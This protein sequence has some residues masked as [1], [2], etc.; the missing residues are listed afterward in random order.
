MVSPFRRRSVLS[1]RAHHHLRR[2]NPGDGDPQGRAPGPGAPGEAQGGRARRHRPPAHDTPPGRGRAALTSA[3]VL[4]GC[5][6]TVAVDP[7]PD[8][9]NPDCAPVM[10]AMPDEVS[11]MSSGRRPGRHH[12]LRDPSHHDRALRRRDWGPPPEPCTD[13]S[14]V[15]W[16]ISQVPR[17]GEPV[18]GSDL[19]PFTSGRGAL[20]RAARA[21]LDRSGGHRLRQCRASPGA[22]CESVADEEGA[23]SP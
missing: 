8:A 3:V 13:V 7:L 23:G 14:G 16:L 17:P 19:R 15:D 20:R 5:G 12:H 6:S 9:A 21:V 1:T 18:A 4:T 10:L 2:S 11:G 22:P